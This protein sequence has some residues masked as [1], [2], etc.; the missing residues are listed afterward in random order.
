MDIRVWTDQDREVPCLLQCYHVSNKSSLT[1]KGG[2]FI[3]YEG[4]TFFRNGLSCGV[5]WITRAEQSDLPAWIIF[6]L[7]KSGTLKAHVE[8]IYGS[9][10]RSLQRSGW[11]AQSQ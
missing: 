8:G 5:C 2:T 6:L 11:T 4:L 1:A 9:K 10:W 7:C 3:I